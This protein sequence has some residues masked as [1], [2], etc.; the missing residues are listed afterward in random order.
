MNS[1]RVLFFVEGNTDIRFV[2]GLSEISA[3]TMAI[4]ESNYTASGLKERLAASGAKVQ[5]DEIPG[6]RLRFQFSSLVYL[7][8]NARRFDV[9]LCQEFLRGAFNGTLAGALTNTPAITY[10]GISPVEYFR[11]RRER[12]QI[13]WLRAWLGES[14]IRFLMTFNGMF[15]TKC[16]CMGT[17]LRGIAGRY[18]NRTGLGLYYGVDTDLF[19]PVGDQERAELRR[20]RNLPLDKFVIFLSSRISHEKDPETVIQAAALA[21]QKGLDA[22]VINLGGGFQDFLNL[23]RQLVGNDADTWVL[24]RPAAHPMGELAGY[25]QAAD[26]LAQ[27][28]LAEGLGLSPLEALACGTPA[29]CTAVGGL[30]H[31]K[32]YA[33]LTTKRDPEAMCRE[34]LWLAAN[35]EEAKRQALEGREYVLREWNRQK[36]FADLAAV[37]QQVMRQAGTVAQQTA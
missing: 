17:Y 10:M 16:L 28:S 21:R 23:A 14:V 15:A 35:R 8:R 27:A 25:Y 6:G 31:L 36:A 29:V 18:S 33:R 11:C 32:G 1:P 20:E 19:H 9:I 30:T 12:G 7:L 5:V 13:G 3:L 37:F 34:F 22:V 4:P 26:C 24:G 2:T